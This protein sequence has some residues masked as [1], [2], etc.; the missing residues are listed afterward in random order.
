MEKTK[1]KVFEICELKNSMME[2]AKE[3]KECPD[4]PMYGQV[5][6][7]IKDLAEAEKDMWK[8]KYYQSIVEAMHEEKEEMKR[9]DDRAGYDHWRY[10]SGR[11][12]PKGHGHHSSGFTPTVDERSIEIMDWDFTNPRMGYTMG[13]SDSRTSMRGSDM[14]HG[15]THMNGYN[16]YRHARMGYHESGSPEHKH[17]MSEAAKEHVEEMAESMRDIWQDADPSLKK[18]LKSRLTSLIG[19]MS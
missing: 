17:E 5:V 7:M 11:F 6:D 9:Y 12:A 10:S 19:E 3:H 15:G 13:S 4:I 8:A 1:Q 2:W 16:R 14:S 18:E